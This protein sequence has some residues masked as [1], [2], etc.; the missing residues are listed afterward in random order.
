MTEPLIPTTRSPTRRVRAS[1]LMLPA[2]VVPVLL[3]LW[4]VT[5]PRPAWFGV[6]AG[7]LMERITREETVSVRIDAERRMVVHAVTPFPRDRAVEDGWLVLDR[8]WL[9]N[10]AAGGSG[11][12]RDGDE[13]S[14]GRGGEAV[15]A[16]GSLRH[17]SLSYV[18][19]VMSGDSHV[20]ITPPFVVLT[21]GSESVLLRLD[22]G[23]LADGDEATPDW[24]RTDAERGIVMARFDGFSDV[25]I[26]T[27]T[28]RLQR[29]FLAW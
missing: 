15:M 5:P 14:G 16:G 4:F 24:I 18:G 25:E 17:D 22:D 11:S 3:A 23:R 2:L 29:R 21:R 12:G 8:R 20:A 13:T 27:D 6:F 7:R 26:G 19:A 28:V 10:D 9:N 1:A